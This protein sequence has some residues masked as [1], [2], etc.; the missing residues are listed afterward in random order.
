MEEAEKY[1]TQR[2]EAIA[3][4]GGSYDGKFVMMRHTAI[5]ETEHQRQAAL[6]AVQHNLGQFGNLM[7]KKG[8][9][10]NGFPEVIPFEQLKGNVRVDPAMLEQNLMFGNTEQVVEKLRAYKALGIDGFIYYTSM[11]LGH[12]EQKQ[13]LERFIEA[14]MPHF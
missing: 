14:V 11:G 8:A 4:V 9:V 1:A 3:K 13:S 5:Y 2:Q 7:M 12:K 6:T 10:T